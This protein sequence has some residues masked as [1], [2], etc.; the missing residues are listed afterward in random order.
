[1][2]ALPAYWSPRLQAAAC[3]GSKAKSSISWKSAIRFG[4]SGSTSSRPNMTEVPSGVRA[5]SL[6]M[7]L[8]S[9]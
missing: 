7:R 6:R 5:L 3:A 9:G 1:L 2:A 8:L 4:D